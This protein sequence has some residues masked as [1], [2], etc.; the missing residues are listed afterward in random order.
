M[1]IQIR[2]ENEY[3]PENVMQKTFRSNVIFIT[4][5]RLNIVAFKIY[6]PRR[7]K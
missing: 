1:K 5:E 3:L 7:T 2:T 4:T 6:S